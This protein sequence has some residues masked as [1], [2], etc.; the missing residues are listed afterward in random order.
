VEVGVDVGRLAS[1]SVREP[2]TIGARFRVPFG[3][4]VPFV[5]NDDEVAATVGVARTGKGIFEGN[6]VDNDD[7]DDT[8]GDDEEDETEDEEDDDESLRLDGATGGRGIDGDG[9]NIVGLLDIDNDVTDDNVDDAPTI[10]I[11]DENNDG[12]TIR[13]TATDNDDDGDDDDIVDDN[14]S[15]IEFNVGKDNEPDNGNG[16]GDS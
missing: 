13:G 5:D 12:A 8:D 10:P 11:G 4:F 1:V 7:D 9:D 3:E 14:E 6:E 15:F 16:V 2:S